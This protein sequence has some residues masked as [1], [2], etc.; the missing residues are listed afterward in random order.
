[1]VRIFVC[2]GCEN[3]IVISLYV[4]GLDIFLY[5]VFVLVFFSHAFLKKKTLH[6]ET[7]QFWKKT[8]YKKCEIM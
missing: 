7:K 3:I 4:S 6:A 1:M 5:N 8:L 2:K